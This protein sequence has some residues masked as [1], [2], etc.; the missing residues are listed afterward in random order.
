[1][2]REHEYQQI[3]Q[4]LYDRF[5][6]ITPSTNQARISDFIYSR[7][8]D[9]VWSFEDYLLEI[10]CRDIE[11]DLL[12]DVAT[13]GET[14]FFRDQDHFLLVK[15]SIYPFFSAKKQKPVVWSAACSTGEEAI[16]LAVLYAMEFGGF[17][18]IQKNLWASDINNRSLE[19]LTTGL[20]KKRS[21]R[22]DG[23]IF[24][25]LLAQSMHQDQEN[26]F[27]YPDLLK[28]I[29]ITR[30]NLINDDLNKIPSLVD[31]IFLK[32]MMI[33][34]PYDKRKIIYSKIS[35]KL[36]FNGVLILG[37]SELPFFENPSMSLVEKDKVFFYV[38]KD[39][40]ICKFLLQGG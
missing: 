14:Y 36:S 30:I 16:S 33:Y 11:Q 8:I 18:S 19:N 17:Q 37:K 24:H 2:I 28:S 6:I 23:E 9:K 32:N 29:S 10:S 39:S 15:N 13:I 35:E 5:A 1:M 38:K 27:I 4:W 7:M 21:L 25:S 40:E 3:H 22:E 31:L 34:F 20:Y 26:Y 12:I